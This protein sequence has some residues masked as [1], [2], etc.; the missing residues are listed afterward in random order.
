[1][2]QHWWH[3]MEGTQGPSPAAAQQHP[4]NCCPPLVPTRAEVSGGSPRP[5]DTECDSE[6]GRGK[7]PHRCCAWMQGRPSGTPQPPILGTRSRVQGSVTNPDALFPPIHGDRVTPAAGSP[8]P[9][10]HPSHQLT[11]QELPSC[12]PSG[13]SPS[14]GDRGTGT[15]LP[16]SPTSGDRDGKPLG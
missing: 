9:P 3:G 13:P 12:T 2:A 11:G 15:A 6:Q 10:S 14:R 5:G 8:S 4:L 1:M 16:L 7:H